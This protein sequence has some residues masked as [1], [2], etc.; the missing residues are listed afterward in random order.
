MSKI[1]IID[2]EDHVC[3]VCHLPLVNLGYKLFYADCD[4][5]AERLAEKHSFDLA[6]VNVVGGNQT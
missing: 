4:N 3:N 6:I 2:G 1:L 5:Q